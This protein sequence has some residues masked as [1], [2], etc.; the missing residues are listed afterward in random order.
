MAPSDDRLRVALVFGGRS[1]EHEVSVVSARSVAGALDRERYEIVPMAIDRRGRWADAE[2]AAHVLSHSGDRAD[3]VVAFDGVARVDPRLLEPGLD[4]ALPILHGPYGEDGTIQGLFEMLDLAYVGCD[5][6]ASA[7]CMDKALTK[8]LLVQAGLATP[9]WVELDRSSWGAD[10]AGLS[11]R[12]L[13]LGLPVFVKPARLGS[14]VGISK[15][16]DAAALGKAVDLALGFGRR[17]IVERGIEAREIEVAVLGNDRPRGSVPGEV[18]P[19]H[20]FYDY[21]DKYLDD[22]CQLLAPAPLDDAQTEAARDLAVRVFAALG[23]AGMARVD[24]FLERPTGRLLVNEV[25]TIP[26]FTSISMYPRLWGLS[27][28]PYPALLDELIRLAGLR[29]R[30]EPG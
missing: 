25:N 15:I 30:G 12:C 7:V 17:T 27:G 22:A 20:E 5:P 6:A 2:T 28:L 23:C 4:V 21:E 16:A 13:E 14:S 18:V 8:R 24:L 3:R 1:G 26:G 10:R 9:D 11:S 19:G 29:H